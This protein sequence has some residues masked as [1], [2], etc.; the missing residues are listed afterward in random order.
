M[1][2]DLAFVLPRSHLFHL[3]LIN[4]LFILKY[5]SF[6]CIILHKV[7]HNHSNKAICY[8]NQQEALLIK[9]HSN[10]I[11]SN[12]IVYWF[13]LSN[14]K[15]IV[16]WEWLILKQIDI[17]TIKELITFCSKRIES[18]TKLRCCSWTFSMKINLIFVR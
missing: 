5:C 3:R 10:S 12:I 18:M 11:L 8:S 7:L 14:F 1:N 17:T 9:Y 13:W 15:S 16:L 2:L 6:R 4:L